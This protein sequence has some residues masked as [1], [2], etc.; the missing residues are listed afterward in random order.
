MKWGEKITFGMLI[1]SMLFST[2][3]LGR[4][5][6]IQEKEQIKFEVLKN[7]IFSAKEN[8]SLEEQT[9]KSGYKEFESMDGEKK[10]VL[11]EYL[12]IVQKN[13]DF[14][15]WISIEGT[16]IDYPVMHTPREPEYYLHRNLSGEYS[17][18]GVPFVGSGD[19]KD[20]KEDII[21]YGHNM[22]NGTMFADLSKYHSQAYCREHSVIYLDTLWE[23]WKFEIFAVLEVTEE[24]WKTENG[25]FYN[26]VANFNMNRERYLKNL[27]KKSLYQYG[28][29]ATIQDQLL[30]LVTCSN[31]EE[32]SRIIVA[33]KR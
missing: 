10:I 15:G 19:M 22:R 12:E 8:Y 23:R 11:P 13:S 26:E 1:V 2:A 25:L 3:V 6:W 32:N 18:A 29:T 30:F 9:E 16:H 21:L 17:Y 7:Q 27:E 20:G 14:V 28:I 33:G 5:L 4:N 24:E 31:Q